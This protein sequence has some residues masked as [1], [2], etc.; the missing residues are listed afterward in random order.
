MIS[1][2]AWTQ[3]QIVRARELFGPDPLFVIL[4]I[5]E[6]EREKR[7]SSRMDRQLGHSWDPSWHDMPGPDNLYDLVVD[8]KSPG[9]RGSADL[10]RQA[11]ERRW[12]DLL[13]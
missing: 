7:E 1:E 11:A 10:V 9:I 5:D 13:P 3:R 4:R 12:P 6:R 8:S 2:G